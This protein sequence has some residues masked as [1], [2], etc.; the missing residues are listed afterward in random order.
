MTIKRKI[1]YLLPCILFAVFALTI[2]LLDH[3]GVWK[4]SSALKKTETKDSEGRVIL[5]AYYDKDGNPAV[6][7]DGYHA[8]ARTYNDA[9][10]LDEVIYQDKSG[11]PVNTKSGY[12]IIERTYNAEGQIYTEAYYDKDRQPA[13]VEKTYQIKRRT[14]DEQGRL[15][16]ME[17]LD[18]EGRF[19]CTKDGYAYYERYY[20]EKQVV[21]DY[22]FDANGASVRHSLGYYGI[23][24]ITDEDGRLIRQDHLNAYGELMSDNNGVATE[25]RTYT[26]KGKLDTERYY[27]AKGDPTTKNRGYYGI[28]YSGGQ[29][30]Y[31]NEDGKQMIRLDNVLNTQPILVALAGIL[32]LVLCFISRG[33]F[34]WGLLIVY[35]GFIIL[36]T[37]LYREAGD[38]RLNMDPIAGTLRFF[39]SSGERQEMLNNIWLFLPFGILLGKLFPK[40]WVFFIPLGVSLMIES[41]Q[42]FARIGFCDISDII[43]NTLGGV[44][45]ILAGRGS[46][47][48]STV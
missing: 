18:Q 15:S 21:E 32:T 29:A 17:F 38:Q 2:V 27:D 30:I 7:G 46:I 31:L 42:Y 16:R 35:L 40:W 12:A 36:M 23:R 45:G 1:I 44:F 6:T 5:T 3:F 24:K 25:T 41:V 43:N 19:V 26:A 28:R 11:A 39:N 33:R 37:L 13:R 8:Q 47:H 10:Q 14:Y 4:N 9:G 34:S 22:Y 20:P 48:Q